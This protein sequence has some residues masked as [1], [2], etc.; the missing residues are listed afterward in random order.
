MET[1]RATVSALL[2]RPP[3]RLLELSGIAW[4]GTLQKTAARELLAS[5][6]ERRVQLYEAMKIWDEVSELLQDDALGIHAAQSLRPG[7]L[8]ILG[9]TIRTAKNFGQALQSLERFQRFIHSAGDM[10]LKPSGE[11]M[12]CELLSVRR[13]PASRHFV[14]FIFATWLV[15]TRELLG[16]E[17]QW[18]EAHFSHPVPANLS[19]HRAFFRC[20]VF[21]DANV[22]LV[23]APL[24]WATRTLPASDPQLH[25]VLSVHAS[26][27][28]ARVPADSVLVE[29][30]RNKLN[31][32]LQRGASSASTVAASLA[33]S[34][35]SL[36]RKLKAE[37]F[38]FREILD[39]VRSEAGEKYL[40][41]G[42][43][44]L[45]EISFR[46]G[47]KDS[48]GF[49]RARK[50]WKREGSDSSQND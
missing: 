49:A 18:S 50:R 47:Y 26:S 23:M 9:F 48:G 34:E 39:E 7:D 38:S 28:A 2:L 1:G 6:V 25:D 43:L 40:Q 35:R 45:S 36:R 27:Q 22:D 10:T 46:L 42:T 17:T 33:L 44:S 30:V 32:E 3:L 13:G 8:D 29:Q 21:F 20:P 11:M 15:V 4:S 37:G 5:D 12:R 31:D 16:E 14:E 41:D 19:E 24:A